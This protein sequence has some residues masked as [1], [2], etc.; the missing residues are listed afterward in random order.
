LIHSTQASA[1]EAA[2][3]IIDATTAA[4]AAYYRLLIV[5]AEDGEHRS[6][7]LRELHLKHAVTVIRAAQRLSATLLEIG[8]ASRARAVY[9]ALE[10]LLL[11]CAGEFVALD[12]LELLF[13]PSLR[14]DPLQ[15]LARLARNRIVIAVWPGR[16]TS[17]TLTYAEPDHPEFY[18]Q[19][20]KDFA[21]FVANPPSHLLP[22]QPAG[23]G[24]A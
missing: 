20:V 2:E 3:A 17:G 14:F 21:V 1:A 4:G 18:E 10:V 6:S 12:H 16:L 19:Q 7:I 15:A 8:Q 22:D 23:R 13:E 24:R 9:P 11:D 5:V